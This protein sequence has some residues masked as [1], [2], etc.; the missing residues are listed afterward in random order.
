VEARPSPEQARRE[1][2]AWFGGMQEI[3]AALR[4]RMRPL[5]AEIVHREFSEEE[6]RR[7]AHEVRLVVLDKWPNAPEGTT[8]ELHL[9][10]MIERW[11]AELRQ[12]VR[13]NC[14]DVLFIPIFAFMIPASLL[15]TV[16][17][18]WAAIVGGVVLAVPIMKWWVWARRTG[19]VALGDD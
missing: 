14:W 18:N 7:W 17:P 5:A 12:Q 9:D 4:E 19:R 13:L 6:L 2:V 15:S 16:L 8:P 10:Q 1:F 11:A 3:G